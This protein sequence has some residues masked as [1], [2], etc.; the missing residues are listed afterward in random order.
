[1]KTRFGAFLPRLSFVLYVTLLAGAVALPSRMFAAEPAADKKIICLIGHMKS[2]GFCEHEYQAGNHLIGAW[3]EKAY[4][5]KVEAR[6]AV[7]W[8]QNEDEFFK[9]AAA[10]VVFCSG[11][12]G[13]LLNGNTRV[14]QFD[15]IMKTGAGLSCL[16]W[17]VEVP[18]GV[19]GN[20]ML[21][22]MGGHYETQWSVNPHWKAKFET[23]PKHEA[24]N[25]LK[26]FEA[27]DEWYFHM[28]FRPNMEG[29]V[30]ILSAVAPA[31]TMSRGDG[32]H[33]GNPTVRAEVAAGQPQH[34]AW[35][36][37]RGADYNHGRGFGFTGLHYHLNWTNDT[38]RKTVLN[39]VAW[40]AKLA[41]PTE[42][43]ESARPTKEDL[44]ANAREF[45]QGRKPVAVVEPTKS[46]LD[47]KVKPLFQS[48]VVT[49]ETPGHAVP[50]DV[51]LPEG[52]K[53]LYLV[54]SD[55]DTISRDW[56]D[57][58][59]PRL[60]MADGSETSL[61]KLKWKSASNGWGEWG[62]N[63]NPGGQTLKVDGKPV[64][65]GIGVHAVSVIAY[66]LP[67][68]TKR[69]KARGGLDSGGTD[70]DGEGCTV[71][72]LVFNANPGAALQLAL[73]GQPNPP[74]NA[75]G[76]TTDGRNST[77]AVLTLTVH[78]EL[79]AQ[80]FASE[81]MTLSPSAIDVDHRGRVWVCEV[82]NYR[83][84][85]GK[86]AAGD[87]ILILEDT[88]GDGIADK[89]TVFY[90]GR[91]VDSAHGICV[92]GN[93]VII[94]AGNDV[95]S[96]YDRDG[97]DKSDANSKELMFT[98]IGGAQ[99]D[100]GIHAF[101]FG[102]DGR[103]YFNFG[104]AGSA[105]HDASGKPVIDK[106]GREARNGHL[107]YQE[108]MVFRC[109]LDG[110]GVETIGWN[111][112]NNWEA[113]VDS[114]GTVWQS[115]NDDDGNQG[116]RIN[117]VMEYGNYG[118][119]DENN[120]ASWSE[121]RP[122][123]EKETPR[124]HWHLNDPGV[125]P[126]LLQ[127][128]GGSPTGI[129]VY[130]GDLLPKIF[131]GQL[132]HCDAGPNVV[133]AYLTKPDGAGY[134]ATMLPILTGAADRWFRPSDVCVAPDGSL[135]VADW[136]D[137]GVGGHGM[138][139]LDRG[140]IFRVMPKGGEKYSV[141]VPKSDIDGLRSPN[142]AGRYLAWQKLRAQG[143]AAQAPLQKL[144]ADKTAAPQHRARALWLLARLD[145][146]QLA[147]AMSDADPDIRITALRATR[148]LYPAKVLQAAGTLAGDRDARVRREVSIAIRF[149]DAPKASEIWAKLAAQHTPGD[150]WGLEALGI[151]A[152]LNW[153]PRLAALKNPG[154]EIIWRSRG[155]DSAARIAEKLVASSEPDAKYIRALHFQSDK[156]A[157]QA[158]YAT[159]FQKGSPEMAML[160]LMQMGAEAG[161]KLTGNSER[162]NAL[163][164]PLRGQSEFVQVVERLNLS[165]FGPELLQFVLSKPES[166]EAV[167]AARR[168]L[169][170]RERILET[171][172]SGNQTN[173]T[174]LTSAL[175][176]TGHE[177]ATG[178]LAGELKRKETSNVTKRAITSALVISGRGGRE[179]LEM[180]K[181]G[182]L[183]ESLKPIAASGLARSPDAA[184]RTE[185][186]KLLQLPV[187]EG[188]QLPPMTELIK[189]KG[190][191]TKGSAAF[192]KAG[193]VACHQINGQFVDFGPNLS[194]IGNKLSREALFDSILYPSAAIST[195]FNGVTVRK[196]G[197]EPLT[198]F[199]TSE[200]QETVTM[201]LAG[202]VSQAI[203]AKEITGRETME[204]SLMPTGLT[205]ALTA[206]ELADLVAYLQSLK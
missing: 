173:V 148:Q 70:Q 143:K 116:V 69:F 109:E 59:E 101:H 128:G 57:W 120:R 87:R 166:K 133:R 163:L 151:G 113:A 39:G 43:I 171:L 97:D 159:I 152:D 201:R 28:R 29:V 62:V 21:N 93:R 165:G 195:G 114:F 144:F 80:L 56:A 204:L 111:F 134:S 17:G 154:D 73:Q 147:T 14:A 95:F 61:T 18:K 177:G 3:L 156:E 16:H 122:G 27:D 161:R 26:P 182:E 1:M 192:A 107:P 96:L 181:K 19:L 103:L 180:V 135:M 202:G 25:G 184:L 58:C 98:K 132:I 40:T 172:R 15:K 158:A 200:T 176:K 145:E 110:S 178:L 35:T 4:P 106:A 190:D 75:S 164:T 32:D 167:V 46:A 198:G 30:P 49:R 91:D 92:L 104:N 90:Q 71:Q 31:S 48:K 55:V 196:T 60:V 9:D 24:A 206:T 53:E 65:D 157:E 89:S 52:S 146:T 23:F 186:A 183:D 54:V 115:D 150:R 191:A 136:Y 7:N 67:A 131:Q 194:K 187:A 153:D 189:L 117:Y 47:P 66:D 140:R 170:D 118:Y 197:S 162:L 129:A 81:P 8:P 137:P 119:K 41:I 155:K 185:A 127:T 13:H 160:A 125:V 179:V 149:L 112:R 85:N 37:Q 10:A 205:A 42:G 72:F 175:G 34:V 76:K 169:P 51:A 168:L 74:G 138:G 99:H 45:G 83:G 84:H 77:N 20:G 64:T 2:H 142:A 199:I 5:G 86:R 6:Y 36:Y 38:F 123:I 68:G 139:D 121:A 79:T 63:R 78:P 102:P 33:S 130:E 174:L 124:R 12:G 82:I 11:G 50:L 22:W 203:P 141:T 44:V 88:N 105:L 100:H 188:T 126:N 94:S 193:C 108:G